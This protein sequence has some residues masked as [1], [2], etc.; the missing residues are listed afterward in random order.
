MENKK[1]KRSKSNEKKIRVARTYTKDGKDINDAM[2]HYVQSIM[3]L[4]MESK[5]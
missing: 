1:T 4:N 3:A 5:A 2:Q